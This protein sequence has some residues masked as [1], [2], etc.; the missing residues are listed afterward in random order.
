MQSERNQRACTT[1]LHPS[2]EDYLDIAWSRKVQRVVRSRLSLRPLVRHGC[3]RPCCQSSSTAQVQGA[4]R[5]QAR[6]AGRRS[7]RL[8]VETTTW[9]VHFPGSQTGARRADGYSSAPT[10]L[11]ATVLAVI[12][13]GNLLN[14]PEYHL[15]TDLTPSPSWHLRSPFSRFLF[16]SF[17][18]PDTQL[19]YKGRE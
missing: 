17:R 6:G 13:A 10:E 14:P 2:G 5:P 19:Y 4:L 8:R 16:L 9:R 11:S 18:K 12:L 7:G 3:R 15:S 1:S